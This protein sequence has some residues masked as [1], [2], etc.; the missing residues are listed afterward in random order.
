MLEIG[1]PSGRRTRAVRVFLSDAE[2][3]LWES[4]RASNP[5]P[6]SRADHVVEM[7]LKN[8]EEFAKTDVRVRSALQAWEVEERQANATGFRS[9]GGRPP[10]PGR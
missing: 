8:I 7:L 4:V 5:L 3:E 1:K 6:E 10:R 9:R 2:L